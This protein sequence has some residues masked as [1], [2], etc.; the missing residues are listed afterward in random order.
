MNRIDNFLIRFTPN[1]QF[2][3]KFVWENKYFEPVDLSQLTFCFIMNYVI[4][5]KQPD[6]KE[7]IKILKLTNT[8]LSRDGSLDINPLTGE[9][10]LTISSRITKKLKIYD[11]GNWA[12]Y[13]ITQNGVC[14]QLISGRWN[15][16]LMSGEG[17]L[18]YYDG[19]WTV[20][21]IYDDGTHK[22]LLK[23]YWE[24]SSLNE[25]ILSEK[26]PKNIGKWKIMQVLPNGKRKELIIGKWN[27]DSPSFQ[28]FIYNGNWELDIIDNLGNSRKIISGRWRWTKDSLTDDSLLASGLWNY[29]KLLHTIMAGSWKA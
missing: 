25:I 7:T 20:C 15:N 22:Q 9:I 26:Y 6:G 24:L 12:I 5:P 19:E 14:K 16:K 21:R 10:N 11:H 2:K 3:K 27:S 29:G 8:E 18:F 28:F 17:A 1:T 23:G 4:V 13:Y